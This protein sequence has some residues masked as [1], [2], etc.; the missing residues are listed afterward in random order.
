MEHGFMDIIWKQKCSLY[1]ELEKIRQDRKRHSESNRI[2]NSCWQFSFDT[3]GVVHHKFLCQ[4]QTMNRW[5]YLEVL[6]RLRENVRRTIPQLWRNNSWFLHHDKPAHASLLI[7]DFLPTQTWLKSTLKGWRFQMI[8][9][10]TENSQTEPL[11]ISK[12]GYQDCFQK[13][14]QR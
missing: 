11:A 4:G 13:W 9:E 3:E 7:R 8:Q 14:Q 12:K 1:N 6:P 10:I 5:Y 2:W